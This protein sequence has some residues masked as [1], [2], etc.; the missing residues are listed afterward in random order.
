[1]ASVTVG[2]GSIPF[3][4]LDDVASFPSRGHDERIDHPTQPQ[5]GGV[6]SS[7]QRRA[8]EEACGLL[9]PGHMARD[10]WS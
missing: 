5:H 8:S 2:N 6:D 3:P 7:H 9:M 1:M 4:L 10:Q